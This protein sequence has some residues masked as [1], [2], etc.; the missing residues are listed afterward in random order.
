MSNRFLATADDITGA[1]RQVARLADVFGA[2]TSVL[3]SSPMKALSASEHARD[4][5][6]GVPTLAG[7][8]AGAILWRDH[9]VLG[10]V[11]GAS[12]ARNVP[13]LLRASERSSATWNLATTGGGVLGSL[14]VKNHPIAGFVAGV[15]AA[16]FVLH[17]LGVKR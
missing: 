10:A 8:A 3:A 15:V 11:A 6:D 13:A 9:R 12:L 16:G 7:A 14:V 5:K 17:S 2:K 4:V 1:S